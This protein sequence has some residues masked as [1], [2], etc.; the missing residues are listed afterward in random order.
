[1]LQGIASF[2]SSMK[3]SEHF[4]Q[5]SFAAATCAHPK[6]G[7]WT[8]ARSWLRHTAARS[9]QLVGSH[10]FQDSLTGNQSGYSLA[11]CSSVL[12]SSACAE[13]NLRMARNGSSYCRPSSFALQ[14]KLQS[15]PDQATWPAASQT[16]TSPGGR[17]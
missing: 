16:Q 8:I 7:K 6:I 4:W 9:Y 10:S 2:R 5:A 17:A 3:D 14:L 1:M 12:C 13:Q 15:K 11:K